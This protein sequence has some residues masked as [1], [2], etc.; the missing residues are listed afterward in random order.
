MPAVEMP[1]TAAVLPPSFSC[2]VHPDRDRVIVRLTGELDLAEAP[3]VAK[4]IEELLEVGFDRIVIDLRSL[5]FMDSTGLR[6]LLDARRTAR[7]GRAELA[8][9]RGPREVQR[10]FEITGTESLF[11]FRDARTLR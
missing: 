3:I 1:M 2:D 4:T 8:L 10:V 7:A 6:M 5:S 11:A 9:V